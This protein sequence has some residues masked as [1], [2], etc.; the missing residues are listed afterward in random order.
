MMI[1]SRRF[2]RLAIVGL[3]VVVAAAASVRGAVRIFL[4]SGWGLEPAAIRRRS[5]TCSPAAK[6]APTAHGSHSPRLARAFTKRTSCVGQRTHRRHR[7]DRTGLDR[8]RLVRGFAHAVR[9]RRH[10][11]SHRPAWRPQ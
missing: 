1:L 5:A 10:H 8:P 6:R 4:P 11:E 9:E 3:C 7:R 2:P